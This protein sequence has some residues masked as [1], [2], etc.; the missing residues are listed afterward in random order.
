M[1]LKNTFPQWG[2][3]RSEDVENPL[4]ASKKFTT[5]QWGTT[6]FGS[7]LPEPEIYLV[8]NSFS[9]NQR[10]VEGLCEKTLLG[11]FLPAHAK[12]EGAIK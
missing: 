10:S 6:S 7:R 4:S 1:E 9:N 11:R 12:T 5:P 3:R 8:V 2:Q